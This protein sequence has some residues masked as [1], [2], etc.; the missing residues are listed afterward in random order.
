MLCNRWQ[1]LHVGAFVAWLIVVSAYL[2]APTTAFAASNRAAVRVY[3]RAVYEYERMIF[4]KVALSKAYY[5][6]LASS[7][8]SECAGVI[9][10]ST[11][12]PGLSTRR[13][14]VRRF[15][16]IGDLREEVYAVLGGAL[17]APDRQASFALA[18][19]LRRLRW[20]TPTLQRHLDGYAIALEHRFKQSIPDSCFDMK[21]W[22][23]SGYRTLSAATRAFLHEYNPPRRLVISGG[24][25][26]KMRHTF[27]ALL[28][29]ES[30]RYDAPVLLKIYIVERRIALALDGL[31]VVDR[32]LER[33]LGF[34]VLR[35]ANDFSTGLLRVP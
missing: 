33:K 27:V 2:T 19:K 18:A 15:E 6:A 12:Q 22:A 11:S 13:R 7:I 5:E 14:T 9:A 31:V 26:P 16:Q 28:Q 35:Q 23:A 17:L 24:S 30:E 4:A 25:R 34:P 10:G 8:G 3:L 1:R 32:N 20:S 29:R 21:A